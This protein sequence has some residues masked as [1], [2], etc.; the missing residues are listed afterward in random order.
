LILLAHMTIPLILFILILGLAFW[1][2]ANDVSK[3][4]A[5]LAGSGVT[6]LRTAVAWGTVC[7]V[8]GSLTAAL[9]AGKL[10]KAFSG[11]GLVT[12]L[13]DGH[14]FRLA[15]A[16]GATIWVAAA[17]FA[18]MPV[19]TTHAITGSLVGAGLVVAGV[20]G[21]AWQR[22]IEKFL[23]PLAVSPILALVFTFALYPLFQKVMTKL[24]RHCLCLSSSA[25]SVVPLENN[26]AA[27]TTGNDV[28]IAGSSESCGANPEVTRRL[29]LLDALHWLSSGAVSFARGLNDAPKILGLGLAAS[30]ALNLPANVAL[31]AVAVAMGLGS[32]LAGF[33]VTE[34]LATKVTSMSPAEGCSANLV[35]AALVIVA[36]RLGAPVSTTHVSSCSIIGMGLKR[37]A[38]SIQ[39]KTVREMLFAWIVT[40]PVAGLIAAAVAWLL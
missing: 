32:A 24:A 37:D 27:M 36:S 6:R 40:L 5:T 18:R 34:T 8:A 16:T 15:V 7:T 30:L 20:G 38:R 1:N 10:L 39:W 31:F 17:T 3:G 26:A 29:N 33:K 28:V 21:L 22:L 12:N 4:I 25:E 19:S 2:G 11:G 35:T 9:L 14:A 13:P 23:I